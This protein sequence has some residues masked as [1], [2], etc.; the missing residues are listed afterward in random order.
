MTQTLDAQERISDLVRAHTAGASPTTAT[1]GI[2]T[3]SKFGT[4]AITFGIA[5]AIIYTLLE[6]LNWPL[7]TYHPAVNKIDFWMQRPR[8][9]EGPPMYWYGWLAL[10]FPVAA[11]IGWGATLLSAQALLR[12]TIFG[13]A[14]ALLWWGFHVTGVAF[15]D[16]VSFDAELLKSMWVAAIP[17][18]AG[19][20]AAG[21]YVS[22]PWAQR[23]WTKLL[24]IAPITGMAI[25][26]YSL[27]G[28]F[29]R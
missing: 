11:L 27:K 23:V 15:A 18:F 5:F 2:T 21:Y 20:A 12:A 8:S 25:L 6:Q 16:W 14:L 4:F 17:A 10:S 24:L 1:A 9:G 3:A 28:F 26:A 7:F 13:C 29:L 22:I 19:A